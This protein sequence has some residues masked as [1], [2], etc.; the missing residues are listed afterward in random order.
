VSDAAERVIWHDVECGAYDADL[1]LWRELA[2]Q[3][4]GPVLDV[5]AGTG[6]VTL[7]LAG[8]G[9]EVVALD[10]DAALL[11]AL[12]ERAGSLPIETVTADAREFALGRR[13]A[14]V[15]VP[16]QTLQL[17]GGGAGR[18]AF[19]AC[20]R[21]HLAAGGVLAVALADPLDGHEPGEHAG[22]DPPRPDIREVGGWVYSSQPVRVVVEDGA[23]VIERLRQAVSPSGERV[24]TEDAVRLDAITGEDLVREG[25]AAGLRALPP[26]EVPGTD[27]Y[28]ASEIVLFA[29]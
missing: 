25:E 10:A 16:M 3:A 28:I 9:H 23:T 11:D 4:G 2:A 19:L 5:G 12:R 29:A 17:L 7:H 13:F 26:R 24:V 14:L 22:L 1:P 20:A 27:D 8:R 6:R 21:A 15:L 18:A